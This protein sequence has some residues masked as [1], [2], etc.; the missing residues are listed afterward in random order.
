MRPRGRH[1][2]GTA[3][4]AGAPPGTLRQS[5]ASLYET[6]S[7]RSAGPGKIRAEN[8]REWDESKRGEH[9]LSDG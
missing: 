2:S 3:G 4:G 6:A 8:E 9:T 5:A 1:V 7:F